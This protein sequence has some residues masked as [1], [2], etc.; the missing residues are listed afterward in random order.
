MQGTESIQDA[1]ASSLTAANLSAG[2]VPLAGVVLKMDDLADCFRDTGSFDAQIYVENPS[3]QLV[4]EGVRLPYAGMLVIVNQDRLVNNLVPCLSRGPQDLFGAQSVQ[5][6][7]PCSGNGT[8]DFEGDTIGYLY[9]GSDRPMCQL[10]QQ[11]LDQ[12][13]S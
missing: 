12:F 13:A 5:T 1:I 6:P 10:F 7:E 2:N 4:Q 11:H 8:F 9:L 3:D